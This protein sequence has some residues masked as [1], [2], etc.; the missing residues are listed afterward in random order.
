MKL[1]LESLKEFTAE[2]G[3]GDCSCSIY[4]GGGAKLDIPL[5]V[6]NAWFRGFSF[7]G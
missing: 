1:F 6:W 7:S 4:I 2:H 5:E 3:N